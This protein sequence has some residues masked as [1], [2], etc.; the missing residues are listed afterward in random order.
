MQITA[1][2]NQTNQTTELLMWLN[3]KQSSRYILLSIY[4]S[5]Q[6]HFLLTCNI[7]QDAVQNHMCLWDSKQLYALCYDHQQEYKTP[8]AISVAILSWLF[9]MILCKHESD[10]I[11]IISSFQLWVYLASIWILWERINHHHAKQWV[12]LMA[13]LLQVMGFELLVMID[14]AFLTNF[15]N[16]KDIICDPPLENEAHTLRLNKTGQLV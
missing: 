9:S 12:L 7:K 13:R 8:G 4:R 14:L 2:T 6:C 1:S 3:S 16:Q 5:Q 10:P 15:M 11:Q